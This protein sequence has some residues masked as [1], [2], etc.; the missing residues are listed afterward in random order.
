MLAPCFRAKNL[1]YARGILDGL[2]HNHE[3]GLPLVKVSFR[4]ETPV[5][6]QAFLDA[7][8]LYTKFKKFED[9]LLRI[10]MSTMNIYSNNKEWLLELSTSVSPES[11]EEFWE[12]NENY[13][14]LLVENTIIVDESNGFEYKVTLG[15]KFGNNGFANFAKANPSLVKVGPVLMEEMENDGYVNNLYFYARDQKVL[16]LCSLLLDNVRR[17]DKLVVKPNLDKQLYGTE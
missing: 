5:S 1:S 2:Q 7:K 4:K 13:S 17:I 10:E 3:K 16:N 15:N 9:Y 11:V 6:E 12:P 14:D 8:T